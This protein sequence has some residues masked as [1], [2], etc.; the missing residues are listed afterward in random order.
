MEVRLTLTNRHGVAHKGMITTYNGAR[1]DRH[2][3]AAGIYRIHRSYSNLKNCPHSS[4]SL[5][6]FFRNAIAFSLVGGVRNYDIILQA[7]GLTQK[8]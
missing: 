1:G 3:C 8:T 5:F 6:I 7:G 4:V 2:N